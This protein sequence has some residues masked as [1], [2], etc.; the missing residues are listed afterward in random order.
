MVPFR[1]QL[2]CYV[3]LHVSGT[4]KVTLHTYCMF[5]WGSLKLKIKRPHLAT[6]RP[7]VKLQQEDGG[8]SGATFK[9]CSAENL[10]HFIYINAAAEKIKQLIIRLAVLV[11]RLKCGGVS[12]LLSGQFSSVSFGKPSSSQ[13]AKMDHSPS[14]VSEAQRWYEARIKALKSPC[15]S[16]K[17]ASRQSSPNSEQRP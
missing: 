3:T 13:R 9:T 6:E 14:S 17:E 7:G 11:Q 10:L 15:S 5:S 4:Q 12:L 8:R 2:S 1:I 16:W